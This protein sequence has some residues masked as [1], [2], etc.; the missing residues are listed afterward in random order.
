MKDPMEINVQV[1]ELLSIYVRSK[2]SKANMLAL[3][4]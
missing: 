2:Y 4:V 3:T 1:I